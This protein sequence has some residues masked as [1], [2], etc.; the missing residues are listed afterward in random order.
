MNVT[1]D[2]IADRAR[3]WFTKTAEAE[4]PADWTERAGYERYCAALRSGSVTVLGDQKVS[5]ALQAPGANTWAYQAGTALDA[6]SQ[7]LPD[8][9][10][11]EEQPDGAF[12]ITW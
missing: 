2:V 4:D 3:A 1:A 12:V 5:A 10:F 7:D 11:I 8:S 6:A 9:A